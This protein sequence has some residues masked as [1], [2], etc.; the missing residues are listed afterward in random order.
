MVQ[1]GEFEDGLEIA[2]S[3]PS[4]V[5]G[6]FHE[7]LMPWLSIPLILTADN[8]CLPCYDIDKMFAWVHPCWV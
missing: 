6:S 8:A 1:L 7:V 2:T 5:Q 4:L 3:G